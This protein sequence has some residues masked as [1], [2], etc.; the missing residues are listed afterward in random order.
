MVVCCVS[1]RY[2]PRPIEKKLPRSAP[3]LDPGSL[4][5]VPLKPV[6]LEDST[7]S[8]SLSNRG[9]SGRLPIDRPGSGEG[10]EGRARDIDKRT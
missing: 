6:Q 10:L 4:L 7:G 1:I 8:G 5:V 2:F 9:S 3:G